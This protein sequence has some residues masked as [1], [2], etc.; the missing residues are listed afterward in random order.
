MDGSAAIPQRFC[1]ACNERVKRHLY[2]GRMTK[3][4][5]YCG[6][7]CFREKPIAVVEIELLF[8]GRA[9]TRPDIRTLLVQTGR[10]FPRMDDWADSLKCSVPYLY[11]MLE[12]YFQI[13]EAHPITEELVWRPM[14]PNE[15]R[16][17]HLGGAGID[18]PENT[19]FDKMRALLGPRMA[20]VAA[21]A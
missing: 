20:F 4:Y 13:Q 11:T 17:H 10:A 8:V 2:R 15:F 3:R 12:R 6:E 14:T 7:K 9:S 21:A 5:V 19:L 1:I 16:R 18:L